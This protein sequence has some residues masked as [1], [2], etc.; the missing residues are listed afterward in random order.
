MI[1]KIT[2]EHCKIDFNKVKSLEDVITVLKAVDLKISY[3]ALEGIPEQF[4]ELQEK[5]LLTKI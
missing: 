5:G 1:P 2:V 4:K 3:D